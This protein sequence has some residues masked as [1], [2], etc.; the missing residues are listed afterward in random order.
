[1]ETRRRTPLQQL[2]RLAA[3]LVRERIHGA[4][5]GVPDE[6]LRRHSFRVAARLRR[7]GYSRVVVLA[8]LLHDIVEDGATSLS[9]LRALGFP[10]RTVRLVDLASHDTT[11]EDRRRRWA[12]MVARLHRVN[13]ADA[14]ALKSS[15]L[16][17]NLNGCATIPDEEKRRFFLDVKGPM[18][19]RLAYPVLGKTALYGELIEAFTRHALAHYR[20]NL[21][22]S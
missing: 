8:G 22:G 3:H 2:D 20:S 5:K 19:L 21:R 16:I 4:R 18:F 1:M 15:D 9:E 14:W 10:E 17:D 11:D 6:P 13:D 7:H 12:R